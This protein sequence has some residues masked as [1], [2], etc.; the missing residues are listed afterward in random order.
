M[1]DTDT[2]L[3]V[4]ALR[5]LRQGEFTTL[6][7]VWTREV[8][9]DAASADGKLGS[10]LKRAADTEILPAYAITKVERA[11]KQVADALRVA[12]KADEF[13]ARQADTPKPKGRFG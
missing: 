1:P 10:T 4:N 2:D 11:R 7:P 9:A 5:L 13:F 3:R 6:W 12:R 8:L